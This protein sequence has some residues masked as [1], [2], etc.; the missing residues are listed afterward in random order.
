VVELELIG[1][2]ER[3]SVLGVD[4]ANGLPPAIPDASAMPE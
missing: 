1:V 2:V 3:S 4:T